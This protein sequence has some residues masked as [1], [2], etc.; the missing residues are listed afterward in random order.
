[1]SYNPIKLDTLKFPYCSDLIL[2]R[3]QVSLAIKYA[4]RYRRINLA[5]R[6]GKLAKVKAEEEAELQEEETDDRFEYQQS[7]VQTLSRS[8][9][10]QQHQ[11]QNSYYEEEGGEQDMCDDQSGED[12]CDDTP[13]RTQGKTEY[14]RCIHVY[15]KTRQ[16]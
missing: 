12:A 1:M 15:E 9:Q 6:L 2:I 10:S 16:K 4:A 14:V 7:Q 5:E 11:Q 3:F 13:S 8:G